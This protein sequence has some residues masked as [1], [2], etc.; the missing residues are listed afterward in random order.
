MTSTSETAEIIKKQDSP[1]CQA[2]GSHRTFELMRKRR[3]VY[4]TDTLIICVSC[5]FVSE[6]PEQRKPDKLV[7]AASNVKTGS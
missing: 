1:P 2:C 6:L 3:T 5:G 7:A 4:G